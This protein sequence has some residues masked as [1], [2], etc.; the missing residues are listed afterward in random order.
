MNRCK[1]CGGEHDTYGRCAKCNPALTAGELKE[2]L[3]KVPDSTIVEV[4]FAG[5]SGSR[6]TLCEALG[7]RSIVELSDGARCAVYVDKG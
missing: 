4:W 3:N 2:I 1:G 6:R 5:Q 7:T